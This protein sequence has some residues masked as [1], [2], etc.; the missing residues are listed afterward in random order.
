[1]TISIIGLPQNACLSELGTI[2]V[3]V[4]FQNQEDLAEFVEAFRQ[5]LAAG[6]DRGRADIYER[7]RTAQTGG[8]VDSTAAIE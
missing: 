8:V 4:V 2:G 1:M 3:R 5:A 6:T 7:V